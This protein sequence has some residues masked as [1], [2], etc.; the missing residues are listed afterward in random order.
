[1]LL[2]GERENAGLNIVCA[3]RVFLLES[4]V[5]HAFEVQ[6]MWV[7]SFNLFFFTE[8]L[9]QLLPGLTVCP[10]RGRPKVNVLGFPLFDG[11][12]T[13]YFL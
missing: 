3:S 13:R 10:K 12:L 1:M 2:H 9:F 8:E 7:G 6:G 11:S 5:N 4:V